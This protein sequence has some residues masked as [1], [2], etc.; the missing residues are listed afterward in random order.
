MT[1]LASCTLLGLLALAGCSS[2]TS[3][4]NYDLI[5]ADIKPIDYARIQCRLIPIEDRHTCLTTSIQHYRDVMMEPIPRDQVTQ[6]PMVAVVGE[7]IYRG[8]YVSNPFSAAFTVSSG[9]NVCRGRFDAVAGETRTIYDVYCDNGATG[10]ANLVLDSSGSN[11]LGIVEMD[12]GTRGEIVFGPAAV[13][14]VV[15]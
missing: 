9:Y 8:R 11:G 5:F 13:T 14:E 1:R 10:S 12:D 2:D 7:E 3:D 4:R 15:Y 6:G